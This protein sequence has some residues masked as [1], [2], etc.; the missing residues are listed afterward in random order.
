VTGWRADTI[1][2]VLHV[3]RFLNASVTA[4]GCAGEFDLD[5]RGQPHTPM[6]AIDADSAHALP[7]NVVEQ[8]V[9]ALR[10]TRRIT[11][12]VGDR[13]PVHPGLAQGADMSLARTADGDRAVV[14]TAD[15][16][17]A[18]SELERR[19]GASPRAAVSLSWH[20]RATAG[21]SVHDALTV[22]SAVYSTLLAGPDFGHWLARRRG[23][24]V[25]DG[26]E[27]VR[28][29]RE[30]DV[31]RLTL[32]RPARRNAVDARMRDALLEALTVAAADERLS[33][34]IDADGPSFSA[35]G[36][37]DEF[38]T[39]PDPATAHLVRVS[40]SVG[41]MLHELRARVS[42]RVHGAC[43]GAGIELPAFA[44]QVI[45]APDAVFGLPEVAMGLIPGAGG[46]VSI[47][48]RIGRW[49]TAWMAVTGRQIDART[50]LE[51][52]LVDALL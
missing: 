35:G 2:V 44:G 19:V 7:A 16:A 24:R 52:G 3:E 37:L 9:A 11:V 51:W 29:A 33:V 10:R 43:V 25:A 45:A 42:V 26:P 38:G 31:L 5:D 50:A 32:A 1:I 13:H 18:L 6:V 17:A 34:E 46:T 4:G 14:V 22:E 40:A 28:V 39:T 27:R 30:G 41:A 36:D 8:A 48:R 23:G 49:R 15:P 12:A 47:P 20:L 21:L